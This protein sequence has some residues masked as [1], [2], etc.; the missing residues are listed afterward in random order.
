MENELDKML[1]TKMGYSEEVES[2]ETCQYSYPVGQQ[3][4]C[5]YNR[6]CHLIVSTKGRCKNWHSEEPNDNPQEVIQN[7]D[8]NVDRIGPDI[9]PT[10]GMLKS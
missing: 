10:T 2:C 5:N 6:A 7:V 9:E 4:R 3:L 8:Q 1:K